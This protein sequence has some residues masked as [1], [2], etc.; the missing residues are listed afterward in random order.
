LTCRRRTACRTTFTTRFTYVR[1]T[2][3]SSNQRNQRTKK[4]AGSQ[5]NRRRIQ[6]RVHRFSV[7]GTAIIT[8][9]SHTTGHINSHITS[10]NARPRPRLVVRPL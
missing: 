9:P 6:S 7:T 5:G 10:T 3:I 4:T 2:I 1:T 8:L